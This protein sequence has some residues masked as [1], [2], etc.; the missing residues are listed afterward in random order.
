MSSH[1]PVPVFGLT[2]EAFAAATAGLPGGR[3]G[4]LAIYRDTWHGLRLPAD[5]SPRWRAALDDAAPEPE[6][7]L[8]ESTEAG[9]TSKCSL[10][11]RDGHR[12]EM[13]R[14]PVKGGRT[15]TLCLSSQVG[16]RLGCAFCETARLGLVRD[17]EPA[18]IAGQVVA[19]LRLGW[20]PRNLV[21]MGMG[22]PLDNADNLL[23]ALQVLTDVRGLG[24][25]RERLTV[26]TAGHA[27]G[28]ARLA[29]LGWTRLNLSISLNAADDTTR[30]RLMPINR[31][32]PLSTLRNVLLSY[33]KR[34][35]F[36]LGVNW[37][38]LPGINNSREDARRLAAFT[39]PLGRVMVNVIPYN[40]GSRPLSRAPTPAEVEEFC[41]CLQ[42]EGLPVRTRT[43]RGRGIMAAC[44]QLGKLPPCGAAAASLES[45][46][47]SWA[48]APTA[49]T[50]NDGGRQPSLGRHVTAEDR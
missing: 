9:T 42:A 36:A 35:N 43:P 41:A 44:G 33:P 21:F 48:E 32:T 45:R 15:S 19:A 5:L 50:G 2:G 40:P 6:Q 34:R 28:I 38:L 26:C 8:E 37:C 16:C 11:L 27:E 47:P 23:A 7:V 29:A 39:A 25:A 24:L 17:L 30:T 4:A 20:Q 49:A 22:E 1:L 10:R 18:E 31:H 12:I 3:E 46:S 14:I 13:V